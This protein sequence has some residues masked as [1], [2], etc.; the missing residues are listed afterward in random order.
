MINPD[1]LMCYVDFGGI[2][3]KKIPYKKTQHGGIILNVKNMVVSK[4]KE[5]SLLCK[6][7]LD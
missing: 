3:S 5:F 4:R 2:V 1:D 7:I 6:E